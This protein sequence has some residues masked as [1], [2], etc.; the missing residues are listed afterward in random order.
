MKRETGKDWL[1]IT[2]RN[3]RGEVTEEKEN[4]VEARSFRNNLAKNLFNTLYFYNG[5]RSD[6]GQL[7]IE[8]LFFFSF[9]RI[10]NFRF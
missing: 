2:S 6:G 9:K 3:I 4:T 8:I 10:S 5:K 1:L 7:N